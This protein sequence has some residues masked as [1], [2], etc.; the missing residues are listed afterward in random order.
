[1]SSD[2]AKLTGMAAVG[3]LLL[4]TKAKRGGGKRDP[5]GA[6]N[7][8]HRVLA[9]AGEP[10][11]GKAITATALG[12]GMWQSGAGFPVNG[13][14]HNVNDNLY[15]ATDRPAGIFVKTAGSTYALAEN[16]PEPMAVVG[17]DVAS[18]LDAAVYVVLVK[19]NRIKALPGFDLPDVAVTA[20]EI[21]EHL[22]GQKIDDAD[23]ETAETIRANAASIDE[24][25]GE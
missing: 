19:S 1:M 17:P 20:L 11:H 12:L 14:V 6:L 2:V 22:A 25:L 10:M 8:A 7:A 21:A 23:D 13:L 24:I 3:S 18:D 4:S 16:A 5:R 15:H 9:A